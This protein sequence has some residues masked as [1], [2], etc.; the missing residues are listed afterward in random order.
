MLLLGGELSSKILDLLLM[1]AICLILFFVN[2]IG[3]KSTDIFD[4]IYEELCNIPWHRKD[5]T[6]KFRKMLI[7]I[8]GVSQRSYYAKILKVFVVGY[9]YF[10]KV[11]QRHFFQEMMNNW[12][13]VIDCSS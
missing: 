4:S 3:Q 9:P 13:T 5:F 10:I 2:T 8:M 7:L 12:N 1:A 11:R 6:M